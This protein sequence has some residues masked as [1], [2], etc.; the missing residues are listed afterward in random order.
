MAKKRKKN[1]NSRRLREI[2][3]IINI[4]ERKKFLRKSLILKRQRD[5][6]LNKNH[7]RSIFL[8]IVKKITQKQIKSSPSTRGD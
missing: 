4:E 1:I 3:C 6:T 7:F 2:N 8:S 5:A